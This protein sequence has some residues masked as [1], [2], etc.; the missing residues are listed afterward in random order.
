MQ[1]DSP[2]AIPTATGTSNIRHC[3]RCGIA[4]DWRRN[5]S[6]SLRMTYCNSLC[7]AAGLGFT[8]EAMFRA[9]R[10]AA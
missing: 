6:S 8:L 3:E 2:T 9:T 5:V 4:Y 1:P 7:E 10:P